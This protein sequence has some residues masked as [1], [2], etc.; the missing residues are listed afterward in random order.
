MNDKRDIEVSGMTEH[1][2]DTRKPVEI[3]IIIPKYIFNLLNKM[4]DLSG[5]SKERIINNFIIAE[6]ESLKDSP[7][8][9][10]DTLLERFINEMNSCIDDFRED[11]V[12]GIYG[13]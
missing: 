8:A 12:L 11:L 5:I 2:P 6:L 4:S 1:L 13:V 10:S 3:K 9:F 7:D